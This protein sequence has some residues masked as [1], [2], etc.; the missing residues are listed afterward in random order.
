MFPQGS[1]M[2]TFNVGNVHSGRVQ[3]RGGLGHLGHK[4]YKN[5]K[6]YEK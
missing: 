1:M 2:G 5:I 6:N 3:I 4:N